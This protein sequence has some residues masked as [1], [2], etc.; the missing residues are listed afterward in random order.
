M[1][2]LKTAEDKTTVSL[3]SDFFFFAVKRRGVQ[4]F[5]V[6]P[7]KF[8]KHGPVLARQQTLWPHWV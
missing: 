4:R 3:K 7:F 6:C 2:V 8:P 5:C 1:T